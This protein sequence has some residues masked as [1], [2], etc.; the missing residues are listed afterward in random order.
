M[1]VAGTGEKMG[2]YP[3]SC[4]WMNYWLNICLLEH[5]SKTSTVEVTF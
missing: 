4:M 2:F 1:Q 3:L 5:I